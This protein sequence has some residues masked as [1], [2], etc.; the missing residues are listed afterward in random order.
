M[1]PW[2]RQ[3]LLRKDQK[4]ALS[5]SFYVQPF[6]TA[7][8]AISINIFQSGILDFHQDYVSVIHGESGSTYEKHNHLTGSCM[9]TIVFSYS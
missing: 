6:I 4:K 5:F 1:V 9:K 3:K 2:E 7:I 8:I